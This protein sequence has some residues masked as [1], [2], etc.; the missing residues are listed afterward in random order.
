MD[1]WF[2]T[3]GVSFICFQAVRQLTKE[4]KDAKTDKS[5]NQGMIEERVVKE[6]QRQLDELK[7]SRERQDKMLVTVK[8][9]R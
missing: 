1:A 6:L 4:L 3:E 5:V 7:E 8:N 9:A 2:L